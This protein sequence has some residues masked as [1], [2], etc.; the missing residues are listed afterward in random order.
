MK[1][2]AFPNG[3]TRAL[4]PSFLQINKAMK[5]LC[6]VASIWT[7]TSIADGGIDSP[8]AK[9][10][11]LK[12]PRAINNLKIHAVEQQ[13][14]HKRVG[15]IKKRLADGDFLRQEARAFRYFAAAWAIPRHLSHEAF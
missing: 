10:R 7:R 6:A 9:T 11:K 2:I 15:C 3:T 1:R 12:I 13:A 8:L 5:F 14:A 4:S